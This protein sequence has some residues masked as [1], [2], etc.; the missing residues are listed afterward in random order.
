MVRIIDVHEA[1]VAEEDVS[2]EVWA[3]SHLRAH[4]QNVFLS[5]K[6][7]QRSV[8]SAYCE[9]VDSTINGIDAGGR[10]SALDVF[11]SIAINIIVD[12]HFFINHACIR[13]LRC[14]WGRIC[15]GGVW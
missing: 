6:I 11:F 5:I 12:N 2:S 7:V 3:F 1:A 14:L 13:I 4:V 9:A 10:T 15:G 8:L